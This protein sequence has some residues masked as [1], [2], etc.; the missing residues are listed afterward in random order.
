MTMPLE[1]HTVTTINN[2]YALICGGYDG[3]SVIDKIFLFKFGM[4]K[5]EATNLY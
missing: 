5:E 2:Q 4:R 1:G 3:F